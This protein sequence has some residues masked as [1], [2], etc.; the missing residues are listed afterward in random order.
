MARKEGEGEGEGKEMMI[1]VQSSNDWRGSAKDSKHIS[2]S[3]SLFASMQ[4]QLQRAH[5]SER[6]NYVAADAAAQCRR[7][8]V[9]RARQINK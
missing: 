5:N 2:L 9:M 3:P 6:L 4:I 8:R 7:R 1:G